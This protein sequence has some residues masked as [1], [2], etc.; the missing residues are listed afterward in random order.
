M[1]QDDPQA[2]MAAIHKQVGGWFD[3]FIRTPP[4]QALS[5]IQKDKAPGIVR[6]FTE[7]SFRY[8]GAAPEKWNR[9]VLRE[10]CL[11]IL[12]RKMSAERAFFQ[13][14]APVLS[15]FFRFLAERELLNNV[16]ELA[17][18]VAELDGE[19]ICASQDERNWGPAKAFIMAA[20]K[21][22]VDTC[23][24]KAMSL[25][26]IEHNLR[27]AARMQA[28]EA[29]LVA[30]TPSLPA[31]ATPIRHAEPKVG[32]NAPCPCGSGKKFKKCCGA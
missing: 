12:P 25:F 4:Y 27:Q 3:G 2:E 1:V 17:S 8:I 5:D 10:C 11:E 23:D 7:Y 22:G 15:A 19:I 13:A 31:P 30:S 18:T 16:R 14:V 26:M 21:A 6:F 24:Q 9:D 28:R 32:R 29:V 20:E